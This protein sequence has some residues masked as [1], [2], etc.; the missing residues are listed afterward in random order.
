MSSPPPAKGTCH[1][2]RLEGKKW[3]WSTCI[4]Q[5]SSF[6]MTCWWWLYRGRKWGP[7]KLSNLP[8][9]RAQVQILTTKYCFPCNMF[10]QTPYNSFKDLLNFIPLW[11]KHHPTVIFLPSTA[12]SATFSVSQ[13]PQGIIIYSWHSRVN[14]TVSPREEDRTVAH[15]EPTGLRD[16]Y[17]IFY[18][19]TISLPLPVSTLK[20]NNKNKNATSLEEK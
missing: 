2:E 14:S 13:H 16:Q 15:A 12:V 8:I 20:N 3:T 1:S 7:K 4:I 19:L 5:I 11:M 18:L 10:F 17:R 6:S 9:Q